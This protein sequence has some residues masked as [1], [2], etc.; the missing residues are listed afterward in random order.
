MQTCKEVNPQIGLPANP[1][2]RIHVCQFACKCIDSNP[3]AVLTIDVLQSLN[4]QKNGS[5]PVRVKPPFLIRISVANLFREV[6][7]K[8]DYDLPNHITPHTNVSHTISHPR[9]EIQQPPSPHLKCGFVGNE[10]ISWP[11]TFI[12]YGY[13]MQTGPPTGGLGEREQY[14]L[15][16]SYLIDT[17]CETK[18]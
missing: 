9:H 6:K 18:Q 13:L 5:D 8:N 7:T 15:I 1:Q 16:P 2:T 3:N 11:G 10:R 14:P 12:R 4:A 17:R